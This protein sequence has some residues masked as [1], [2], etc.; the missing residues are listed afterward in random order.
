MQTMYSFPRC[1]TLCWWMRPKIVDDS[2]F[3]LDCPLFV[4]LWHQVRHWM[5]FDS[6][7]PV[8]LLGHFIQFDNLAGTS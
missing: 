8:F 6:A 3:F 2:S 4:S 7:N 5:G 1:S